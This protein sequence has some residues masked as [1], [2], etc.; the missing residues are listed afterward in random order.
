MPALRFCSAF[1]KAR[2][3][4]LLVSRAPI[5]EKPCASCGRTITWRKKWESSWDDVRYCSDACRR[6]KPGSAAAALEDTIL[7]RLAEIPRSSSICPSEIARAH[8]PADW[9]A[10]MEDVRRA[11]ARAAPMPPLPAPTTQRSNSGWLMLDWMMMESQNR[12]RVFARD[13]G[14]RRAVRAR[15]AAWRSQARCSFDRCDR[16][17]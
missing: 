8:F 11:A 14:N 1:R 9:S 7:A 10:H 5:P 17:V 3:F 16:W 6:R 2:G 13:H 12:P 4:A 15:R